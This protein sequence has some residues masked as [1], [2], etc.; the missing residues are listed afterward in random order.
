[1]KRFMFIL[2]CF[3]ALTA[4][5]QDAMFDEV[6][7]KFSAGHDD[8]IA[9]AKDYIAKFPAHNFDGIDA[10]LD[11]S[12]KNDQLHGT[13]KTM[14]SFFPVGPATDI[15]LIGFNVSTFEDANG[16]RSQTDILFQYQFPDRWIVAEVV[17]KKTEKGFMVLGVHVSP[18]R[19]SLKNIHAFTMAGK[20]A[21]NYAML[22]AT[23]VVPLFTLAVLVLCIRT[24]IPKRKWLWVVFILLGCFVTLKMNWTTGDTEFQLLSF[25]LLGASWMKS[26]P[27]NPNVLSVSFPLGAIVFLM[28]RKKL[29]GG[30]PADKT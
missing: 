23:V 17:V 14:A 18:L 30:N 15:K 11:P 1:M 26:S 21:A 10:S 25:Q 8:E 22:A 24:P 29:I 9:F 28:R 3:L 7:Q 20:P 27:Y 12:L 2:L 5:D 13:L 6:I 19:D 16:T 4:C